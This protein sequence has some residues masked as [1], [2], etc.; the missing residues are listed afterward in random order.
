MHTGRHPARPAP[1]LAALALLLGA[2]CSDVDPAQLAQDV[3]EARAG[4]TEEKL[5][6]ADEECVA[7]MERYAEMG[8]EAMRGY[9]GAVK[10]L[11]RALQR[12]GPVQLD[13]AGLGHALSA[14]VE[15]AAAGSL[16]PGTAA[17]R[18]RT[19]AAPAP[20]ADGGWGAEG[21]APYPVPPRAQ[22]YGGGAYDEYPERDAYGAYPR[23]RDAE[24]WDPRRE[25]EAYRGRGYGGDARYH[26]P[27]DSYDPRYQDPRYQDPRYYDPRYED[28]RWRGGGGTGWERGGGY[29]PRDPRLRQDVRTRDR[30]PQDRGWRGREGVLP[31]D[32]RLR[33]PWLDERDADGY[34]APGPG[35]YDPAQIPDSGGWRRGSWQRP[36][37]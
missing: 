25:R 2:A 31:P 8:T 30:F 11:D 27:R 1:A 24:D 33:R 29:D 14:G 34:R 10:S 37:R 13:T 5:Q 17:D 16:A 18:F 36:P 20:A 3:N 35:R 21:S 6:A 32:E 26:D 15:A 28:P 7:M 4:C 23:G 12:M 9:I 22:G 19:R